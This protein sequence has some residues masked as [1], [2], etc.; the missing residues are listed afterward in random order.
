MAA[1][2]YWNGTEWKELAL[3]EDLGWTLTGNNLHNTLLGNVG[4]GTTSPDALL[5]VGNH[6][7]GS[8]AAQA[9]TVAAHLLHKQERW[10]GSRG[11]VTFRL[12]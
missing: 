10:R 6:T 12:S 11:G 2:K 1:F 7:G 3:S 8:P 9:G 5:N 4:I